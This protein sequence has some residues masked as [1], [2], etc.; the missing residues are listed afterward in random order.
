MK[1]HSNGALSWRGRQRL[2]KRVV[3]EGWT[4][5][6][7]CHFIHDRRHAARF[8]QACF[9]GWRINWRTGAKVPANRDISNGL[10]SR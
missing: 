5:T 7:D 8:L 3:L 9:A 2:A 4:L 1:P 10:E 6:A